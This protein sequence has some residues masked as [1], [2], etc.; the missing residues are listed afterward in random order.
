MP[1]FSKN[2]KIIFQYN[3]HLNST[4]SVLRQKR[5]YFIRYTT[6]RN[7][8]CIPRV[9]VQLDGNK[10]PSYVNQYCIFSDKSR[11]KNNI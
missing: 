8:T 7:Y 9:V 6:H 4:S 10:N 5:G 11:L 3:H 2:Q 1:K